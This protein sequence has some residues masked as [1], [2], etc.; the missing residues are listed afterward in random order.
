MACQVGNGTDAV[1][2]VIFL[3][4][5]TPGTCPKSYGV[6]VARLAGKIVCSFKFFNKNQNHQL[7]ICSHLV[8]QPFIFATYYANYKL[9]RSSMPNLIQP[10]LI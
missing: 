8:V 7:S 3:Y 2:E 9:V 4:R 5:L 6:N 1:E 10:N